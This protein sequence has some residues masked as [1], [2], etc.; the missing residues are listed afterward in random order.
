LDIRIVCAFNLQSF[1][2]HF[3]ASDRC[4]VSPGKSLPINFDFSGSLTGSAMQWSSIGLGYRIEVVMSDLSEDVVLTYGSI[5]VLGI[6]T[7]RAGLPLRVRSRYFLKP[8]KS[9]CYRAKC[10]LK[11]KG[12]RQSE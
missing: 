11:G 9:T 3:T 7:C 6:N 8:I 1:V 5:P 4:V 10:W 2:E 12:R